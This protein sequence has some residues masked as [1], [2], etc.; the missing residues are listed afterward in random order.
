M[1]LKRVVRYAAVD[2]TNR[3]AD[4]KEIQAESFGTW[5]MHLEEMGFWW[6]ADASTMALTTGVLTG[7]GAPGTGAFVW[8]YLKNGKLQNV[9]AEGRLGAAMRYAGVDVLVLYGKS[10]TPLCLT[11]DDGELALTEQ[12]ADY[13]SLLANR[14]NED[15]VIATVSRKAVTEDKYF[16]ISDGA[17]AKRLLDKGVAAI[18][19]EATGALQVADAGRLAA[20]CTELYQAG[21][22]SGAAVGSSR[23]H[24]VRFLSL[25][26]AADLEGPVSYENPV[27]AENAVYAALGIIWSK[28]LERCDQKRYTAEL[29]SACLGTPCCEADLDVLFAHLAELQQKKVEGGAV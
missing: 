28:A 25:D 2:L 1:M 23:K 10:E 22:A 14:K 8:S 3:T 5:S 19:A 16:A 15:A 27:E 29:T 17:V 26:S 13:A 9:A 7:T 4:I 11:I 24:P 21:I 20:L 12:A 6:E 18:V